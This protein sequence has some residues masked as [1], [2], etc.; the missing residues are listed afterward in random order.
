M[1]K[2]SLDSNEIPLRV[3]L[4]ATPHTKR[5][6]L[7]SFHNTLATTIFI[8]LAQLGTQTTN[9]KMLRATVVVNLSSVTCVYIMEYH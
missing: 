8:V 2:S 3:E 7:N 1:M 4:I 5:G 9:K 6:P